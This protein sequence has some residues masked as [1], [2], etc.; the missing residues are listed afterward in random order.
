MRRPQSE[1]VLS[2]ASLG[3]RG[4]EEEAEDVDE[5][6]LAVETIAAAPLSRG[7]LR[8][9]ILVSIAA[10][11]REGDAT[12]EQ[13][14]LRAWAEAAAARGAGKD[15]ISLS[16]E[17]LFV[18]VI[19]FFSSLPRSGR[20]QNCRRR[21]LTADDKKKRRKRE[22]RFSSTWL[23]L[24]PSCLA[25][26]LGVCT[27]HGGYVTVSRRGAAK[28]RERR[29]SIRSVVARSNRCPFASS[30]FC[31]SL[32]L[33]RGP[34]WSLARRSRS[35]HLCLCLSVFI[36][37]TKIKTERRGLGSASS[38]W[39][40]RCCSFDVFCASGARARGGRLFGR[41]P[42]P[43]DDRDAPLAVHLRAAG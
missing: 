23:P 14:G 20:R 34:A 24:T 26:G 13:R 29:E 7:F 17:I 31:L 35:C 6:A 39:R 28:E 27:R 4:E 19:F 30:P 33:K 1:S 8:L 9:M 18:R 2:L 42:L 43:Q 37:P 32:G 25:R 36:S 12:T 21:V 41:A 3:A 38:Q 15:M 5:V 11:A 40:R 10:A 22:T 16:V